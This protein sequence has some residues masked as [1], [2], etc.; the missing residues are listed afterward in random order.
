M[1][2]VDWAGHLNEGG[3]PF[4]LRWRAMFVALDE[5]IVRYELFDEDDE[6]GMLAALARLRAAAPAQAR[7]T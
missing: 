7:R 6:V 1:T 3:V 5:S 4:E 2:I